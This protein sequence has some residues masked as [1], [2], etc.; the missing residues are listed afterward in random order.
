MLLPCPCT[1][2][3]ARD[4]RIV[5]YRSVERN[6]IPLP[7]SEIRDKTGGVGCII[8]AYALSSLI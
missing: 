8:T 4:N 3:N 2:V 1:V 6:D 5:S 7:Y